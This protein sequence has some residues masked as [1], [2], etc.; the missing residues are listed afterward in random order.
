MNIVQ[1]TGGTGVFGH[2]STFRQELY[3]CVTTRSDAVFELVDAVLCAD[4]PVR[5]LPELSQPR[6]ERRPV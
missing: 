2:L 4:G 3:R 6:V 1:D 5:S